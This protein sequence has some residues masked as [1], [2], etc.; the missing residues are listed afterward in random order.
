ML[1]GYIRSL[2]PLSK[3]VYEKPSEVSRMFLGHQAAKLCEAIRTF[4]YEWANI[5]SS[6][7]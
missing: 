6:I 2:N 7:R 1:A 3:D 5:G 4:V